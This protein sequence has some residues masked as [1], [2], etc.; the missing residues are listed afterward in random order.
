[1]PVQMTALQQEFDPWTGTISPD[2]IWRISGPWFSVANNFMDPSRAAFHETQ[3]GETGHGYL[4]LTVTP[5]VDP[6]QGAEIQT[7]QEFGYGYYEVNM[8]VSPVSGGIA[9]FFLIDYDN[10][11]HEYDIEFRLDHQNEIAFTNFNG[12]PTNFQQLNFDPSADF[13]Q[14]GI[15]WEPGKITDFVD[16]VAVKTESNPY[17]VSD[18]PDDG[19]NIAMNTWSGL[20]TF[21]GGPPATDS[22][23]VYDWVHFTPLGSAPPPLP[24]PDTEATVPL[25]TITDDTISVA[26]RGGMADLGINVSTADINDTLTIEITGLPKWATITDGFD[27]HVFRGSDIT[28]TEEEANGGLVLRSFVHGRGHPTAQ[29]T[30]TAHASDPSGD[31]AASAPHLVTMTTDHHH[32][33]I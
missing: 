19:V 5:S 1:M 11:Y 30:V 29:L 10:P 8:K 33:L 22:T 14:Y 28:L 3:P 23:T 27:G 31:T 21:G 2:G 7:L 24:P 9:S 13:H 32:W 17:F 6:L 20:A 15:L 25:L 4:D 12:E 26:R 18:G 16:G